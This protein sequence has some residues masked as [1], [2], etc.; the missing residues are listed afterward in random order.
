MNR[1]I[2]FYLNHRM[3]Y[4]QMFGRTSGSTYPI[5]HERIIFLC[6]HP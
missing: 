4:A 6:L 2:H 3:V 5:M 1:F